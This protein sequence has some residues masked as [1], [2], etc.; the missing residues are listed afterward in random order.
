MENQ[1]KTKKK[2]FTKLVIILFMVA[3]LFFI[4]GLVDIKVNAAESDTY[5]VITYQTKYVYENGDTKDG[6]PKDEEYC[7]FSSTSPID[8]YVY[9]SHSAPYTGTGIEFSIYAVSSTP[10]TGKNYLTFDSTE[11]IIDGKKIY[12][13]GIYGSTGFG[14]PLSGYIETSFDGDYQIGARLN[15]N[16]T[17]DEFAQAYANEYLDIVID[18]DSLE[19][20]NNMLMPTN[21]KRNIIKN[22]I[23]DNLSATYLGGDMYDF[24]TWT[25]TS[26]LYSLQLQV[27][28]VVQYYDVRFS[29]NIFTKEFYGEWETQAIYD[30]VTNS[31]TLCTFSSNPEILRVYPA[32]ASGVTFKGECDE[33]YSKGILEENYLKFGYRVRYID[34]ENLKASPWLVLVPMKELDK[35]EVYVEYADNSK[36]DTT[37]GNGLFNEYENLEDIENAKTDIKTENDF[38]DKYDVVDN[39]VDVKEATNWLYSVVNFIGD[40]P[41]LIAVVLP[42]LPK[43]ILYGLYVTVFLGVIASGIA[44][45]KALLP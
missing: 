22:E 35:Y 13:I 30:D 28:P 38:K 16:Y 31:Y 45:V 34:K 5:E 2:R 7:T 1:N 6:Y 40:T 37:D 21:I 3:I 24:I 12:V 20:D 27:V 15:V 33:K 18:Y 44:I 25:N 39:E 26:E 42:F 32:Y 29:E 19:V 8:I 41:H 23:K 36:S 10:F 4:L 9:D 17:K 43:P 14:S 11:Y